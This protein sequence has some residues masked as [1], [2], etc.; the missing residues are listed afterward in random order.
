MKKGPLGSALLLMGALLAGSQ[1]EGKASEQVVGVD[2]EKGLVTLE[3]NGARISLIPPVVDIV[4]KVEGVLKI[5]REKFPPELM[6]EFAE[7]LLRDSS[8]V[9]MQTGNMVADVTTQKGLDKSCQYC[10]G[11]Q[12]FSKEMKLGYV[13]NNIYSTIMSTAERI[14]QY[15]FYRR[16]LNLP[17]P[18]MRAQPNELPQEGEERKKAQRQLII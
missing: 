18:P 14:F 9:E 4:R 12:E 7:A 16:G 17:P 8:I 5:T 3:L 10:H 13:A 1:T 6:A 2:K 11:N 15:E